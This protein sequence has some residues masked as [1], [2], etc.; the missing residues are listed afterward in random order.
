MAMNM[1]MDM[2]E[3]AELAA[4]AKVE[5]AM[6]LHVVAPGPGRYKLWLQFSGGGTLYVAPF[7][8]TA[9]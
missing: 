4:D 9:A 6:A 1:D 7:V 3:P 5:P 2:G 8:L